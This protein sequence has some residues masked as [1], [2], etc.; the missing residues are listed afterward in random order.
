MVRGQIIPLARILGHIEEIEIVPILNELPATGSYCP[1]LP[2]A[3]DPPKELPLDDWV[4]LVRTTVP[5]PARWR[6]PRPGF[7]RRVWARLRDAFG[8]RG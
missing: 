7:W 2:R 4:G 1:L 5:P 8:R 3:F 6:G